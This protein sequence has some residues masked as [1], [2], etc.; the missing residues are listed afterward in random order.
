[1]E[2]AG[3]PRKKPDYDAENI[4]NQL[5]KTITDS[6]LHPA[7][8]EES[9]DDPEHRQLKLIAEEFSMSRLKVRKLLI[10]AGVYETPIS[11]EVNRLSHQGKTI[12]EI[13]EA[14]GLKRASV[15]SYLPYTKTVYKL[16]DATVT[17]E[18]IRK[19]R[20]RRKA[21]EMMRHS[22]ETAEQKVIEETL[23][24]TLQLFQDYTFCTAKNLR[25]SYTIKGNEIFFS[26]KEKS[27]TRATVNLALEKAIELQNNGIKITGPKK[28][29]CFGASY[30]YPVFV[31]IGVIEKEES[32]N[33]I[34]SGNLSNDFC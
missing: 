32:Y 1:M 26:R 19:Y 31:R 33:G 5:I 21:V 17:A 34:S 20:S 28:L 18:R 30:L 6:Y 7:A 10:T 4:R 29:G 12:A 27:V 13:Q 11:G 3:R 25:F 9:P 15:H 24:K 8:G 14:T 2:N 23:W 16:E 22:L